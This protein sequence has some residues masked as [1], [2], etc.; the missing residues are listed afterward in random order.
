M[1]ITRSQT[2]RSS[3]PGNRPAPSTRQPGE[4]YTNWPDNAFGVISASQT[5]VDLLA[6]RF[7]SALATY[8]V[9]DHVWNGGFLYRCTT[10][11]TTAG[12]FTPA[13]WA[14][15]ATTGQAL[16][17]ASLTLTGSLGAW[18]TEGWGKSIEMPG[19]AYA[20]HWPKG[21]GSL[22]WGLGTNGPGTALSMTT[23]T[24]D[25]NSAPAVHPFIFNSNGSLQIAST[26]AQI[27]I[28]PSVTTA[29]PTINLT[30]GSVGA[31]TAINAYSGGNMR[32]SLQMANANAETGSNTGSDFTLYNFADSGSYTSALT[33][34]RANMSASF[35]GTL[36]AVT[37][38]NLTGVNPAFQLIKNASGGT[39]EIVGFTG[40]SYRWMIQLGDAGAESGSDAG[41]NFGL[42]CWNDANSS[43]KLVLSF[44][45]ANG[46]GTFGYGLTSSGPFTASST[47]V[48]SGTTQHNAAVTIQ[49]SG[50][51]L[52]VNCTVN[53]SGNGAIEGQMTSGSFY[54]LL[55]YNG[56]GTAYSFYGNS[57][58]YSAGTVQAGS[59]L[60]AGTVIN[61]SGLS[62]FS[63]GY[64]G[65]ATITTGTSNFN[66]AFGGTIYHNWAANYYS[67]AVDNYAYLGLSS[68]RWYIVYS[69]NNVSTSDAEEKMDFRELED[70]E[71]KVAQRL[72][73][74]VRMFRWK[75]LPPDPYDATAPRKADTKHEGKLS[76]G[77]TGQDIEAAFR[78]EGLDPFA[79]SMLHKDE[80][81]DYT[82]SSG[83]GYE[84]IPGTID[85]AHKGIP[86]KHREIPF[87]PAKATPTGK[88]RYGV[89][90]N[91]LLAFIVS[92]I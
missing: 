74:L 1:T 32:W 7:F 21:S 2:L 15:I 54:A 28:A 66:L 72:K 30:K 87:V 38:I 12:A 25:D 70:A 78:A 73:K 35:G 33:I 85:D 53:A 76:A 80:I 24:A 84:I 47:S 29:A 91:E 41:S 11:V 56:S 31:S 65:N 20:V 82:Q 23:S 3:T 83:G 59:S 8:N 42:Y 62:N 89:N 58:L 81:I 48:F 27:N 19:P 57:N 5:A 39:N 55:A 26:A 6:V 50:L 44:S 90:Y 92:A 43:Q 63:I 14:Q 37:S 77:V 49:T 86:D 40:A 36:T 52:N 45:R 46:Y 51:P 18:T 22:S 68:Y 88:F 75:E 67:P 10:A 16:S 61:I 17:S 71:R 64:G 13:N 69:V 4:L 60:T 34:N 9:G 79:Y